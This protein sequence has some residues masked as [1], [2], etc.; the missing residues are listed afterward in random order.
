MLMASAAAAAALA[1]TLVLAAIKRERG[2]R[3]WS[4]LIPGQGGVLDQWGGVFFAAPLFY[5]L[6]H[7]GWT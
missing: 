6:A 1:G 5:H 7:Y 2:V 4:H 3:D